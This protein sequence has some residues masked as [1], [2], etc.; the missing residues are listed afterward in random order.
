M[1]SSTPAADS[2]ARHCLLACTRPLVDMEAEGLNSREAIFRAH[3]AQLLRHQWLL[4]SML[5][6][7]ERAVGIVES[8][9]HSTM[10]LVRWNVDIRS[11]T[12]PGTLV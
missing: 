3:V 12:L 8:E 11:Y 5:A 2:G 6:G 10:T 7:P 9:M 1:P 4:V